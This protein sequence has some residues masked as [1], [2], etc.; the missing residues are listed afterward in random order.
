MT[1]FEHFTEGEI[2]YGTLEKFGISQEMIDDLP[3]NVMKRLLAGRT[4]P[5]LPII[6]ENDE[7][8]TVKS[9]ARISLIRLHDGSVDIC[10]APRWSDEEL[11]EF[12]PEQQEELKLGKVT[13]ANMPGRGNCYVQFDENINQ[14]MAV[15]TSVINQN[16]SILTRSLELDEYNK[17]KIENGEI[18]ELNINDITISIGI[19][20]N[21]LSGIRIAEGDIIEW[22][23]D[24]NVDKLPKYNFGI[25]GCW[26][27]DDE[28]ML[29][30]ILED[31][32]TEEMILEQ[33]RI[34]QQ[35]AAEE[36][37]R[38]LKIS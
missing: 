17:A 37:L 12:T 10:F 26:T 3:E 38:Q 1:N 32:Y 2:P 29:T 5:M 33:K 34:G 30:Y 22:Q 14:V 13:T 28:N 7:G 31:D 4:T 36:N 25:Y 18:I 9:L 20:L 8:Q 35:K 11:S 6:T 21:E 16:I 15:P 23:K 27:A 24:A 19:D